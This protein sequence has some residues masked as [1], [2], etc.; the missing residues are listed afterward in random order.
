M[1]SISQEAEKNLESNVETPKDTKIQFITKEDPDNE[2]VHRMESLAE[3]KQLTQQQRFHQQIK[4]QKNSDY[5]SS[6]N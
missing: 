3:R 1:I 4:I 6:S 2:M 5:M